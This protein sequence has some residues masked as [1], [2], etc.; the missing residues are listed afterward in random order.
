MSRIN[1]KEPLLRV[2]KKAEIS[3]FSL[4]VLSVVS[5]IV[6]FAAGGIFF[7]ALGI[8]P[9]S[10]YAKI[11]A[12]AFDGKIAIIATVK[13]AVPLLITSLGITLAFKMQF[14]NIGAE[15]QLIM[16]AICASYFALFR[17]DLPH[18]LLIVLM[19]A[20]GVVGGGLWGLI[21][22]F[23]KCKFNTNETLFT[24]MLNYIALYLIVYF[25][26]GP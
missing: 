15:G 5:I 17:S 21:P 1:N 11:F 7:L 2:V 13:I 14:W 24:L 10:A 9:I 8:Y 25:K 16:G 3:G 26:E 18:V 6:A 23:F 12:G 20:A 4:A 19:F 22:A